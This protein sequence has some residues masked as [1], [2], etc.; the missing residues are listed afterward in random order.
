MTNTVV[1]HSRVSSSRRRP[2][3]GP[4]AVITMLLPTRSGHRIRGLIP[5]ACSIG[6]TLAQPPELAGGLPSHASSDI[7][8]RNCV[9][10]TV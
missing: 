9:H 4:L 7:L 1:R 10:P 2:M 5:T 6:F 8:R 3:S